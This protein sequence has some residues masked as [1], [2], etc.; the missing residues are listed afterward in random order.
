MSFDKH[1]PVVG[2]EA[3]TTAKIDLVAGMKVRRRAEK[4]PIYC[5]C[6]MDQDHGTVVCEWP[7]GNLSAYDG[8]EELKQLAADGKLLVVDEDDG[9]DRLPHIIW[10]TAKQLVSLLEKEY[11]FGQKKMVIEEPDAYVEALPFVTCPHCSGGVA[12]LFDD[13]GMGKCPNCGKAIGPMVF[14]N[15]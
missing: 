9:V 6:D 4:W 15:V 14:T 1:R 13:D 8:L 10:R 7:T 5:I 11:G 12:R 3:G 2:Y